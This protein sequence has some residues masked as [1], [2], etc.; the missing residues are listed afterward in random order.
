MNIILTNEQIDEITQLIKDG[1]SINEIVE[2]LNNK[3]NVLQPKEIIKEVV[4]EKPVKPEKPVPIN[5]KTQVNNNV[6][7]VEITYIYNNKSIKV[8]GNRE[9]NDF[10]PEL[11]NKLEQELYISLLYSLNNIISST[12]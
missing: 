9:C 1:K 2:I 4:I 6:V 7:G 8:F 11:V 3:Y 12:L 10:A 5:V